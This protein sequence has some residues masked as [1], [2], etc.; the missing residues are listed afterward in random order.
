MKWWGYK[1]LQLKKE[2]DGNLMFILM[3][4]KKI[5]CIFW[6]SCIHRWA[7]LI[8]CFFPFLCF[9]SFHIHVSFQTTKFFNRLIHVIKLVWSF[10]SFLTFGWTLNNA[11]MSLERLPYG[12]GRHSSIQYSIEIVFTRQ[13]WKPW[14]FRASERWVHEISFYVILSWHDLHLLYAL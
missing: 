11:V 5:N 14:T 3:K 8:V 12:V 2:R 10:R 1:T 6:F 7:L 9:H 4:G 13:F